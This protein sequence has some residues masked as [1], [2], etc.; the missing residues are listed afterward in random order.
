MKAQRGN[1][2]LRRFR[3]SRPDTDYFITINLADKLRNELRF[4]IRWEIR[5]ELEAIEATGY[6][7][8]RGAV[9]MPDHL[10]LL[11]TL[12]DQLNLSRVIARLKTKT[13]RALLA[14]GLRWQPNFYEHRLRANESAQEALRYIFL[15]PY[16]AKLLTITGAYPWYWAGADETAWF[17]PQ[18][19]DG[20]PM[21][22]WLR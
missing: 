1:E 8:I 9:I 7:R 19:D 18:L 11:V 16:R 5:R 12:G 22:E 17:E 10:H 15:N 3:E 13:R 20:R 2:I 14:D 4:G 21:P 6:W